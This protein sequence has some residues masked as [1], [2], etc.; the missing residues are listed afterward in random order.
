VDLTSKGRVLLGEAHFG[1]SSG[2]ESPGQRAVEETIR[3]GLQAL[4]NTFV[5]AIDAAHEE[6]GWAVRADV[7]A[8]RVPV[9]SEMRGIEE[10]TAKVVGEP[11][12]LT[13][14]A[15]TDVLVTG[16]RYE[17]VGDVRSSE[18][19]DGAPTPEPRSP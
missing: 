7:S 11:V 9:P 14:R 13:V 19:P 16:S 18:D 3:A 17:A 10:R 5:T 1:S 12:A 15:R 2:E 8:P 4:P 6:S